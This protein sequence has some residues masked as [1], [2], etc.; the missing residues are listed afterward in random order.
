MM[1]SLSGK[2][3]A[4]FLTVIVLSL[5]MVGFISYFQ[6]SSALDESSE[7]S[8][9]QV[10]G[11]A[12]YQMDLYL[13]NYEKASDSILSYILVKRFLDMDPEDSYSYYQY[14]DEIQK[15][16][17]RSLFILYPQINLMYVIG[18]HGKAISDDNQNQAYSLLFNPAERYRTL[19]EQTPDSGRIAL[20]NTNYKGDRDR[21]VIT[22]AR[23]IRGMSAYRPNGILAIEFKAEELARIWEP[24]DL[25]QGGFFFIMDE[26]GQLLYRPAGNV[27]SPELELP[28]HLT[29]EVFEHPDSSL[30][31]EV[32]GEEYMFVSRR[33]EYS[34]WHLVVSMPVSELRNPIATIRTTTLAVGILTL[35]GT[36]LLA[37]R[38]GSFI[39]K[40][41]IILKEGM[42]ETE[43]GNWRRLETDDRQDELGG[44][45][46]SYNVMVTR[47][48]EMIERVYEAE[49]TTQKAA[50]E[51]QETRL[52]RH[53]AE[54]QALQLQIN[55]HFLYNTLETIKCYAVVQDSGEITEMVEAMAFMLRYSIQTSLEEI[56]IANELRHVLSYMTILKH[57]ID[58]EFEI[59]VVVPP[60]LLLEKTVRLTLQPL[61][62][63]IFQHAFPDGI[64]DRHRIKIDARI[65]GDRFLVIVEDNGAGMGTEQLAGLRERLN[66]NQLAEPEG[67]SLYH[68]GGIGLMNVHRRIQMVFGEQYGLSVESELG[69]GTR[70]ILSMPAERKNSKRIKE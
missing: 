11:S 48:S 26:F 64:E 20:L 61:I 59:D 55:P 41:I 30:I 8:I 21:N 53:Q 27:H 45:I 69:Q 65:E 5:S 25:G 68:T 1:K 17:F 23:K 4:S 70:M 14:T 39:T 42:R 10:I 56:T 62:E 51:L 63:N 33:S 36:L 19:G 34:G 35:A 47:L 7:K 66:L 52:E 31:R 60:M 49:L 15:Y 2:L 54:F 57:R 24:L 58:R 12:S 6:A 22:M 18:E 67:D 43:K 37:M 50:L 28:G 40:P 32:N 16:L 3:F 44:L 13:Q 29:G 9:A 38:F 46:R